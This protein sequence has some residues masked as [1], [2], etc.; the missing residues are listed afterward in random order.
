MK[1]GIDVRVLERK[2]TGVG[3]Y[4]LNILKHISF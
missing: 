2:M 1:I 3:R 4:L